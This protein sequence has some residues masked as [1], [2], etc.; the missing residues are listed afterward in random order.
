SISITAGINIGIASV[1]ATGSLDV[2]CG[3][4]GLQVDSNESI[5]D[6]KELAELVNL[7]KPGLP[8]LTDKDHA[9]HQPFSDDIQKPVSVL[10]LGDFAHDVADGGPLCPFT[11]GGDI[12]V[13]LSATLS[14]GIGPFSLSFTIDFGKFTIASFS[15]NTCDSKDP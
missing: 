4:S 11:I 15:I 7:S 10:Q 3:L 14:V 8:A 1:A 13:G 2:T 6:P 5:T 12:T 9:F